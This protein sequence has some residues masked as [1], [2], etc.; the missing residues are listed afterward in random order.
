M[1]WLGLGTKTTWLGLR[2][3]HVLVRVRGKGSVAT[4]KAENCPN[5]SSKKGFFCHCQ[6]AVKNIQWFYV[7][8]C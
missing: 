2:E 5:V 4:N 3:D 6:R 7:L 1:V 8:E